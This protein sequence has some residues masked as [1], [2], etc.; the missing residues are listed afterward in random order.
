MS[1]NVQ[2]FMERITG[3]HLSDI[4]H[5]HLLDGVVRDHKPTRDALEGA[6]L[7]RKYPHLFAMA[8]AIIEDD[9]RKK[10]EPTLPVKVERATLK[11]GSRTY[12]LR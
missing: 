1:Q 7:R 11:K 4:E 12:G 2:F 8:W 3:V 9:E 10:Q 6:D 5:R